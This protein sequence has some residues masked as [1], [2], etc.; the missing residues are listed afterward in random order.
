MRF[1]FYECVDKTAH[2]EDFDDREP[3]AVQDDRG[4]QVDITVGR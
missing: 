3:Q 4:R 1:A 2:V